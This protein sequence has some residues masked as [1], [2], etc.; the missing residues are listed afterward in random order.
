MRGL[1]TDVR[2]ALRLM[3]RRPSFSATVTL[4]LAIALGAMA[5]AYG[6]ATAVLWRPL[7]FAHPERLV[8]AWENSG[9]E[10]E[11]KPARVTGFRFAQWQRESQSLESIALFGSVGFLT[12]QGNGAEIVN[13]VRVST[14]Y[15]ETL[16]IRPAIGRAFEASDGEPGHGQVVILSHSLWTEWFG[17]RTDVVNRQVQLGG[18]PYTVVGVMPG[19]VFPAWPVNPAAVTLDSDS[20][21]LWVP[22]TRTPALATSARAHV[23]GVVG[24][25][26]EGIS[27][28][29]AQS[30]ISQLT[31]PSDPDPHRALLRPFREQFVRDAR[32]PL[33]AL[34]GAALAVLLAACTN[35]AA[36][37]GASIEARRGELG[38]RAALG[39]GRLRL[40]RQFA[41]EAVILVGSGAALAL[42]ASQ[43]VLLKIPKLLPPSVPLLTSPSVNLEIVAL[44]VM[45]SVGATLALTAW[46]L[47]QARS[48][49]S[50]APRGNTP[51]ARSFVFRALVVVQIALAMALVAA[52]ALLQQSLNAVRAQDAGFTV[53]RVLVGNVTLAGPTYR[54]PAAMV[55]G[56]RRLASELASIP[57][58]A[59]A[60]F[61]YDHPL[62]A[63][64]TDSFAIS[65]TSAGADDARGSAELRIVS[66]SYFDTM[67]VQVL[68]GRALTERDDLSAP[69]AVLVNEAF[70]RTVV[71]GPVLNRTLRSGSPR[72]NWN[73]DA[74]VPTE[75]HIVGVVEDERFKG[76]EQPSAP[77]VYM[78]TRQ[79]PQG[80]LV[81][82]LRTGPDPRAI[83]A[84]AREAVKRFDPQ[85]PVGLVQPLASILA[86]QLVARRATTQVIDGFAAGALGL[87]ALGLYGLLALLVAGR[88]RETG[89]RLALGSSPAV[90]AGRVV[91]ACIIS[92]MAGVSCGLGLALVAGDLLRGLLVGV[93]G[94]D[95]ST[96]VV[97]SVTMIGVALAAALL[98]AWRAAR[99]D[100]ASV[101]RANS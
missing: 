101:L 11:V 14:N 71:D 98:P 42:T 57:G 21:R 28:D 43:V 91:R 70:A 59:A 92:T 64:W 60:A 67:K 27:I 26:R 83:A 22:I 45:M 52:A 34:I 12:D 79:F 49:V 48:A 40:A 35:L 87:A 29:A 44:M 7:P 32:T 4:T 90:E 61:A 94:R 15:F 66:P 10:A 99:V 46:P 2:W 56:E 8:F 17:G 89:I 75:F 85:V 20:R 58:V 9:T 36:L 76:L 95:V 33:I 3:A 25:L 5:S 73:N 39:A 80:Q 55:A 69:G 84:A 31:T 24:R 81:M 100:P 63:N 23:F 6:V 19:V 78:T 93:S 72:L 13:G 51:L 68:D 65:G 30:E 54:D 82:L 41:I 74:R 38:V 18:R 1:I 37:Q 16:G 62:E 50:P 88:M 86:E 96:L 77:A 97:V 53:D 47:A